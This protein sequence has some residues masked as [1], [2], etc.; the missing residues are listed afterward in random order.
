M[1][2]RCVPAVALLAWA[3]HATAQDGLS[4]TGFVD[5]AFTYAKGSVSS[6]SSLSSGNWSTSRLIVRS[7]E[8]LGGGYG[9]GLWMEAA[10]LADT[11]QGGATNSN[12][13]PSGQGTAG[14][15]T[16]G[17]RST[18]SLFAPWG[19]L[20]A[21]RDLQPHY[22]NIAL[23]DPFAHIGIGQAQLL[24]ATVAGSNT[25]WVRASNGLQYLT[26]S[27]L[28]GWFAHGAHFRGE[29]AD[30]YGNGHSLRAG[31]EDKTLRV[32]VGTMKTRQATGEISN[33]SVAA[34][35]TRDGIEWMGV[36]LRD[37]WTGTAPDGK[38]WELGVRVPRGVHEWKAQISRYTT[39]AAASPTST[40]VALGYAYHLSKRT[41]LYGILARVD[42]TGGAARTLGGAVA[43]PDGSATGTDL[44]IRHSF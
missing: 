10:I 5:L 6:A 40:K 30:G 44:G 16:W 34:G 14:A 26:P 11:G 27:T 24:T 3:T 33:L 22:L 28:G 31:Y 25:T 9:A 18:L 17:R 23:F 37:N 7:Q 1:K 20:R 35:W 4:I 13:Q 12:N 42:N 8:D 19:E 32:G 38:G 2:F 43:G 15:M 39:N 21:G 36:V 29:T 41:A